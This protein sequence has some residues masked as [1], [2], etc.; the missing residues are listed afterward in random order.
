MID[1]DKQKTNTYTI[2]KS[3]KTEFFYVGRNND[4][5]KRKLS[6]TLP[7]PEIDHRIEIKAVLWDQSVFDLEAVLVVKKG[8]K[9]TDSYLKID[10]L[11]MSEKSR[12]RVIPSLE[13]M[14]DAVK[15]GH[16]A[17]VS[18]VN[19]QQMHYLRSR[20]LSKTQ[21]EDLIIEGFLD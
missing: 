17:T 14:E 4:Q 18:T 6:F 13:I 16:G 5:F 19:K 10:C 21:A 20:G 15:S 7:K 2:A 8:A 1:L 11:L 9:N 12:A 3:G